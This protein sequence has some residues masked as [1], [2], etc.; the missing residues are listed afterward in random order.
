[1]SDTMSIKK[2]NSII[3]VLLPFTLTIG[4]IILDQV[5]KLLI[6]INLTKHESIKII[7]DLLRLQH[8]RNTAIAFGVGRGLPA[9]IRPI[10]FLILPALV[11]V[12]LIIFIIRTKDLKTMQRWVLCAIVGGGIGNIIDRIFRPEGVVDFIDMKFFGIFGFDRW[13]TYN[14]ADSSIVVGI[15]ILIISMII[16]EIKLRKKGAPNE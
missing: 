13:P 7:G 16:T 4:I 11:I 12:F 6:V 15:S 9:E 8:V 5:T 10:L 2:E 3:A 14:I 1:M